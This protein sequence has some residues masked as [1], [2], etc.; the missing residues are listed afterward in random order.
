MKKLFLILAVCAILICS[1]FLLTG[2]G[3]ANNEMTTMP[4]SSMPNAQTSENNTQSTVSGTSDNET[5]SMTG[6]AESRT[7]GNISNSSETGTTE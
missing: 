3:G 7:D 4:S 1:V 6:N 5:F 2:C